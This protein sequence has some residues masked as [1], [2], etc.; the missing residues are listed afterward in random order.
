MDTGT[1]HSAETTDSFDI[2]STYKHAPIWLTLYATV[3]GAVYQ[4]AFWSEFH[5]AVTQ[6]MGLQDLVRISLVPLIFLIAFVAAGMA[7]QLFIMESWL[8]QI[9]IFLD[10]GAPVKST[11]RGTTGAAIILLSLLPIF[12]AVMFI[13]NWDRYLEAIA[14]ATTIAGISFVVARRSRVLHHMRAR[15]LRD[16]LLAAA[17]VGVPLAYAFATIDAWG[18]LDGRRYIAAK[19]I[20]QDQIRIFRSASTEP[21]KF[22]GH[23]GQYDF[24]NQSQSTFIVRSSELHAFA[25]NKVVTET[26][27]RFPIIDR[28]P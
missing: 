23:I 26:K 13:W 21:I 8:G 28:R 9:P 19:L 25:I 16:L 4:T 10:P 18:V 27:L 6:Y 15:F 2:G 20:E 11:R 5:V 7:G 24:F 14:L 3:I 12:I 17:A 22:I 1:N